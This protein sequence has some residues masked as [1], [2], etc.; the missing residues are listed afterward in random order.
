[1]LTICGIIVK[2]MLHV[3]GS[4]CAHLG[5]ILDGQH[6]DDIIPRPFKDIHARYVVPE[7]LEKPKMPDNI[8]PELIISDEVDS[9]EGKE[10]FCRAYKTMSA[11]ATSALVAT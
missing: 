8:L 5:C 1:M 4:F 6:H 11:E 10:T 2:G 7:G 3:F 9:N